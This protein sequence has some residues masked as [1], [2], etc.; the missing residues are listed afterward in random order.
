MI[1]IFGLGLL[2]NI[3]PC[4]SNTFLSIMQDKRYKLQNLD[5]NHKK[6]PNTS[7]VFEFHK[8]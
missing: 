5:K 1:S 3:I 8:K 4:A 6:T 7:G 2:T